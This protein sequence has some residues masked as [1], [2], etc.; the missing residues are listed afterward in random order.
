MQNQITVSVGVCVCEHR[1]QTLQLCGGCLRK[2]LRSPPF[3]GLCVDGRYRS[4]GLTHG[5]LAH[6][7]LVCVP[8]RLVVVGVGNEASAHP[9]QRE[10]L[11]LQVCCVSAET[12]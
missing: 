2:D 10:G 6:G 8:G 7:A 4:C 1:S 5:L 3:N 9:E 11:N 12:K